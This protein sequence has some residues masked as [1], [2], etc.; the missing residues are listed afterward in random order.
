[1]EKVSTFVLIVLVII[2]SVGL[3]GRI[4]CKESFG[5]LKSE[6]AFIAENDLPANPR[7]GD[8]THQTNMPDTSERKAIGGKPSPI[9][10]ATSA[11]TF[12]HA[13]RTRR[14]L[15]LC[16]REYNARDEYEEPQKILSRLSTPTSALDRTCTM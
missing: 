3:I 6:N 14:S 2:N 5:S 7:T 16:W 4:R 9:L 1:M 11:K 15:S 10:D 8:Q 13:R 12:L